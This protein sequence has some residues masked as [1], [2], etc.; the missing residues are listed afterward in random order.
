MPLASTIQI[1]TPSDFSPKNWE[2]WLSSS[3][4]MRHYEQ[5]Q[6]R[7][8][9][10]QDFIGRS[11]FICQIGAAQQR[12]AQIDFTI[13]KEG[14]AARGLGEQLRVPLDSYFKK[15]NG[16]TIFQLPSEP[17]DY[18][19]LER[20]KESVFA[21]LLGETLTYGRGPADIL[22]LRA[23]DVEIQ[24][25]FDENSTKEPEVVSEL[26]KS[27]Y[28][29]QEV[30]KPISISFE[31]FTG[32]Y[33]LERHFMRQQ[34]ESL[35]PVSHES[36]LEFASVFASEVPNA[37]P[38]VLTKNSKG[39]HIERTIFPIVMSPLFHQM[40]NTSIQ[41]LLGAKGGESQHPVLD[42]YEIAHPR[43]APTS[44][45]VLN[46]DD[47]VRKMKTKTACPKTAA[48]TI[49][50]SQFYN[51]HA[52]NDMMYSAD[53]VLTNRFILDQRSEPAPKLYDQLERQVEGRIAQ[54]VRE[55]KA[56]N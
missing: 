17:S 56:S 52:F 49:V 26:I 29:L 34:R 18:D 23:R 53:S 45:L 3:Q 44:C 30:H 28:R 9:L 13:L 4:N 1:T 10:L 24:R 39:E 22:S 16:A 55:L 51:H 35:A 37:R 46:Y 40:H 15:G 43:F 47:E 36:L 31:A 11:D 25:E 2:Q 50:K 20:I 19:E 38:S 6:N 32:A 33:L 48:R 27:G 54:L 42:E 21:A 41:E 14:D 8:A 5:P 12:R 7:K